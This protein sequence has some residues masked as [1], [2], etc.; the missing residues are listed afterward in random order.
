MRRYTEDAGVD[1][2][3]FSLLL[4]AAVF[5]R[6]LW[7]SSNLAPTPVGAPPPSG[8]LQW[9][10]TIS[11]RHLPRA[12]WFTGL[13][14]LNGVKSLNLDINQR[15]NCSELHQP[16]T[17]LYSIC[18]LQNYLYHIRVDPCR[19]P[20]YSF[21]CGVGYSTNMGHEPIM[22]GFRN[23]CSLTFAFLDNFLGYPRAWYIFTRLISTVWVWD[24]V[25]PDWILFVSSSHLF[26]AINLLSS[27]FMTI[28]L[29]AVSFYTHVGWYVSVCACRF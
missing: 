25:R 29:F 7:Q 22:C 11:T 9:T 2:L 10:Q 21:W 8:D 17:V 24:L 5:P 23:F 18:L 28:V 16:T 26:L 3:F 13:Q 27:L 1:K 4:P 19:A 14:H 6:V 12:A 15:G 20:L